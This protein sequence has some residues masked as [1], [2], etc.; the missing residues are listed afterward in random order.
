MYSTQ[1]KRKPVVADGFIGTLKSKIY[2]YIYIYIYIYIY[3][4]LWCK[5]SRKDPKFK[6]C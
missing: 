4:W 3:N 5:N 2:K 1:N 6:L